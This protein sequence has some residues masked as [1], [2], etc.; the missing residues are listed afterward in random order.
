M[1]TFKYSEITLEE[2]LKLENYI[3]DGDTETIKEEE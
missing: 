3:C 2:T 1:K